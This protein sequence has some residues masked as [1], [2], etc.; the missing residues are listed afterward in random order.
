[1]KNSGGTKHLRSSG[2]RYELWRPM[3]NRRN[4]GA[5]ISRAPALLPTDVVGGDGESR[6]P[7]RPSTD[8]P[9]GAPRRESCGFGASVRFAREQLWQCCRLCDCHPGISLLSG[10]HP[11]ARRGTQLLARRP[12]RDGCGPAKSITRCEVRRPRSPECG[13]KRCSDTAVPGWYAPPR[14]WC[15]GRASGTRSACDSQTTMVYP[16]ALTR[17]IHNS[18]ICAVRRTL[19]VPF[20]RDRCPRGIE[21]K[22]NIHGQR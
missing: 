20:H 22:H 13:T 11:A 16:A 1:M 2:N 8:V 9:R 7:R 17:A 14:R 6:K 5:L 3:A 15:G 21:V 19:G 4:A 18:V 12:L 10:V